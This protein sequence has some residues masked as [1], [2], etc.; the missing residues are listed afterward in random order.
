MYCHQEFLE[1][2]A[3]HDKDAIGRRVSFLMQRMSVDSRRLHYK[4]TQGANRGWRRSRLGGG[5][6][7][8]F[9]AW[10]APAKA[11]PLDLG[12]FDS[13]AEKS[14]FLRDIRH[15]D[16]HSP[17]DA[18]AFDTH[19]LPVT[20]FDM[21]EEQYA[22]SPWTPPQT[23]FASARQSVRLLKGHPGSGKTTALWHAADSAGSNVLYV[24]YSRDLAALARDYFDRFCSA[25]KTFR[26]LT[27]SDL[28]RELLN[29][30]TPVVTELESRQNFRRDFVA[31]S[32]MAGAWANEPMSLYDELHA[33]MVGDALPVTI[34]RFPACDAP[35]V[36]DNAYRERRTRSLGSAAGSAMEVVNRLER[37]VSPSL[38]QSYFPEVA[39]AW[40][41]VQRIR[42]ADFPIGKYNFD[43]IAIDECQDLTP[44]E[45][46]LLIELHAKLREGKHSA[47]PLLFAG[48]EAQTVRPT[49]FE[50]GWLSDLIHARSGAP[51]EF[52]LASNLRSPRRIAS[53]VNRVWDLYSHVQKQERPSGTGAAEIDDD[54]TDQVLYCTAVPGEELN[55]LFA[56]L[57]GREGLAIISLDDTIP[58]WVPET[59]RSSVLTVREAKG[60]DFHSVCIL[61]AGRHLKRILKDNFGSRN[62]DL[63][64]LRKRLAIDQ[65]RV[66]LSRPTERLFWLDIDPDREIVDQSVKFLNGTDTEGVVAGCIPAALSKTLDEDELVP[67]E[68]VQRCQADARQYLQVKPDLAWS[69]AHQAVTL[70]GRPEGLHSVTDSEARQAAYLTLA[71]VCF[72]LGFRN[73]KLPTELG[74]PDLLTE[75]FNAARSAR[76]SHLAASIEAIRRVLNAP[77]ETRISALVDFGRVLAGAKDQLEPWLLVEIEG[78]SKQWLDEL[79]SAL[80]STHNASILL[81]LLPGLM[82]ALNVP[83]RQERL[84]KLRNKAVQV[85]IK[86]KRYGAALELLELLP[87]RNHKLEAQCYQGLGSF[88]SAA[89]AFLA[90]GMTAEAVDAY[91]TI[92][93]IDAALNLVEKVG[94]H[95]AAES[96][97][98][99]KRAKQLME[100]RPEKFAKVI[101]PEEK[102]Y[103]QDIL[104]AGLGVKKRIPVA[105]KTTVK[106]AAPLKKASPKF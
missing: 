42:S 26:V 56:T 67:E 90:A 44:I 34:G 81:N 74:K 22:P 59:L 92:P 96:L 100:E 89:E 17:L 41:A 47:I 93:D 97:R 49:D 6:G 50:W 69:R 3:T 84:G 60:L 85:S 30:D 64:G 53:L 7:S 37:S 86:E 36:P 12:G 51:T 11:T 101:R 79:E 63:E 94:N 40:R 52:R 24:T 21:R 103:L 27:Y 83:D 19:Y 29:I 98:W 5:H 82:D 10:W 15:H 105:R 1:K 25:G 104:E 28:V 106:K 95:P 66:A 57:S 46:L 14:I 68:R 32:R 102:K 55:H 38:A 18:H 45:A 76:R 2:L 58:T 70:L 73:T 91:R 61:D 54:A 75:S 71:E 78:K 65:L 4:A 80:V 62:A 16:D 8:H 72:V 99:V 35:R 48:D 39:L 13:A 31:F 23:K 77:I 87:E 20:V 33:H 43:C 9:Y 88:R